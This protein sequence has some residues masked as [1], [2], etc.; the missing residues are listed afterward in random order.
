MKT[1]RVDLSGYWNNK[2]IHF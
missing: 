1:A 2:D